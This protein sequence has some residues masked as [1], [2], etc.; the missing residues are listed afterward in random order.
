MKEMGLE[1]AAYK[2]KGVAAFTQH[3]DVHML[4]Y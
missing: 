2:G 3:D 4:S 1:L